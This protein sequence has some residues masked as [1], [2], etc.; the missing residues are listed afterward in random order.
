MSIFED[1][2]PLSKANKVYTLVP[3]PILDLVRYVRRLRIQRYKQKKIQEAKTA[4]DRNYHL[5]FKV[6]LN[7]TINPQVT[8]HEYDMIIPAKAA[9]FAKLKLEQDIRKKITIEITGWN[10]I[11]DDEYEKHLITKKRFIKVNT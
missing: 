6:H 3:Q 2:E 7:D 11:A 8:D 4:F 10:E 5:K 1:K 9:Y